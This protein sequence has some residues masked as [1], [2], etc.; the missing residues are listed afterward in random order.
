V[1]KRLSSALVI[2]EIAMSLTLL[3]SA[4]LL[5]KSFWRLIHAAQA[6]RQTTL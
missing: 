2:G 4:G 1:H 6:S 5:L 3:V